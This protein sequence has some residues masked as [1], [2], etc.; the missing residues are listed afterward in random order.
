MLHELKTTTFEEELS[1]FSQGVE[2]STKSSL[3]LSWL[4]LKKLKSTSWKLLNLLFEK[5]KLLKRVSPHK[6][7]QVNDGVHE[8]GITLYQHPPSRFFN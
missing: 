2:Q 4:L 6:R 5:P 7:V 3:K 8:F 1:K